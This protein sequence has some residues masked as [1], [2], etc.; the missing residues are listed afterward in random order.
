MFFFENHVVGGSSKYVL[1]CINATFLVTDDVQILSNRNA[2]SSEEIDSLKLH[3]VQ[4]ELRIA[5]RQAIAERVFQKKKPAD[6]L[7]KFLLFFT[8]LFLLLNIWKIFFL[9]RKIKPDIVISCNGGYPGAESSLAAVLAARLCKIPSI[10]VILSQPALRRNLLLGYDRLL[11]YFVFKSV[12][13]IIA[14][15]AFQLNVLKINRSAPNNKLLR[16][17]NGI[18]DTLNPPEIRYIQKTKPAI[19][20]VVCRLDK[21]KGLEFLIEAVAILKE[22]KYFFELQ[23]IGEGNYRENLTDQ[24]NRLGITDVVKLVGYVPGNLSTIIAPFNIYVFPSLWEGL[25]YSILE[26]L[27]AG[28]PIVSTDVGGIPEAIQNGVDGILVEP[29][30][31]VQLAEAIA[32]LLDNPDYASKLSYNARIR[33]ENLFTIEKMQHDFVNIIRNVSDPKKFDKGFSN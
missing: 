8:P 15:S 16:V 24:I 30:S 21:G 11:D 33:Y 22:K 9:L 12:K 1:D 4:T 26:G 7:R 3:I 18:V 27:R 10:L 25:P 32:Y 23:I 29:G 20:G 5:E 14:N 19:L 28:L 17:Y 31:A 6:L 13:Y 2:F